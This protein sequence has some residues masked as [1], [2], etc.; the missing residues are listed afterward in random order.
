M[1]A[2][3]VRDD[4]HVMA[5][6]GSFRDEEA[7]GILEMSGTDTIE[8]TMTTVVPAVGEGI[9]VTSERVPARNIF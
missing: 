3:F 5:F 4:G 8:N 1:K 2:K 6:A 9:E 7:W